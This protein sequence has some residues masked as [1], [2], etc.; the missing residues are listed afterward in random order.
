[1][2]G[3]R[4]VGDPAMLVASNEKAKAELGWTPA[5]PEVE[6]MIEDAWGFFQS[7]TA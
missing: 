2:V 6:T 1:V 5:R 3:P 7:R 4:R